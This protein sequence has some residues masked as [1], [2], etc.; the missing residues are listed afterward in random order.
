M[1]HHPLD[2]IE[3][4]VSDLAAAKDFYGSAFGW[5]FNDYGP[6]YA[7]IRTADGSDEVGGLGVGDDGGPGGI[8]A[9]VRSGDLDAS[10]TAVEAAGGTVTAPPYDYPGGRRFL[11]S[12]PDGNRLGVYQP[13]GG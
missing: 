9:L 10:L 5:E 1:T 11:L 12:D 6:D 2:Y 13:A 3:I 8:V 7:G 4:H